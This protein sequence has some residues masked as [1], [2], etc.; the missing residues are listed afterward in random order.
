MVNPNEASSH[1][2]TFHICGAGFYRGDALPDKVLNGKSAKSL[3]KP[4]ALRQCIPPP[5]HVLPVLQYGSRSD[6]YPDS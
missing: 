5:R 3:F 1:K 6:P 2:Q 4:A